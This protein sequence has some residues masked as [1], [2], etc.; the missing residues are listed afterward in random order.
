MFHVE[1]EPYVE[2][3]PTYKVIAT[4]SLDNS[5]PIPEEYS[6]TFH[7]V[8]QWLTTLDPAKRPKNRTKLSNSI[9]KMCVTTSAGLTAE[10]A[11]SYLVEKHYVVLK[12]DTVSIPTKG[13][14]EL[15]RS[16]MALSKQISYNTERQAALDRCTAWVLDP[17]NRP[18][19]RAAL[20]NTL[21]QLIQVKKQL[22]P[23]TIVQ[24]LVEHGSLVVLQDDKGV[25]HIEY[26]L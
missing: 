2:P 10:E 19:T 3:E 18:R 23:S 4:A 11:V 20:L 26:Q 24:Y 17:D 8:L 6:A 22:S 5:A 15:Q 7:R 14:K 1:M 9:T 21:R 12:A 13:E 25:E 16:N